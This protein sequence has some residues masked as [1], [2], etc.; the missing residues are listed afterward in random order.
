MSKQGG[1]IVLDS[2]SSSNSNE[3]ASPSS[4]QQDSSSEK[5]SSPS[6]RADGEPLDESRQKVLK[7]NQI[8]REYSEEIDSAARSSGGPSGRT[9]S[10]KAIKL[11]DIEPEM[12]FE[13]AGSDTPLHLKISSGKQV[14]QVGSPGKKCE[15]AKSGQTVGNGVIKKAAFAKPEPLHQEADLE[16]SNKAKY[17]DLEKEKVDE[18]EDFVNREYDFKEEDRKEYQ[19]HLK[20][21]LFNFKVE[22]I[23]GIEQEKAEFDEKHKDDIIEYFNK[24][25]FKD[26]S[27]T[28]T[29]IG[30]TVFGVIGFILF[31]SAIYLSLIG[32]IIGI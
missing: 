11:G 29:I 28:G 27:N 23:V 31:S 16:R 21:E 24:N 1:S 10:S 3:E 25:S 15:E 9:G 13:R 5:A 6:Y 7:D 8:S 18:Y 12:L 22:K 20:Q 17:N 32:G 19:T 14:G 4:S 2:K 30:M 26:K